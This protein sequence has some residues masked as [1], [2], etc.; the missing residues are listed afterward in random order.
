MSSYLTM[1]ELRR[2]L[3]L[4]DLKRFRDSAETR[5]RLVMG[6]FPQG[7][8]STPRSEASIL[9]RGENSAKSAYF[10]IRSSLMPVALPG[11]KTL[12]EDF[13]HLTSESAVT[14]RLTLSPIRRQGKVERF[15]S[16]FDAIEEL[17]QEKLTPA[18]E[19]LKLVSTRDETVYRQGGKAFVK[20]VQCDGVATV[21]DSQALEEALVKGVGRNKSYGAG[22]LTV[23]RIP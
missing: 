4:A 3:A 10:L 13:S 17:L 23:K 12:E 6:I 11:V 16:D 1:V 5:H 22:L 19:E 21:R 18:L 15:L 20:L 14:F 9:F 2:A 7:L 8:G